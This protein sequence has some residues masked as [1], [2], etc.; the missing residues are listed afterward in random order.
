MNLLFRVPVVLILTCIA[1]LVIA[2]GSVRAETSIRFAFQGASGD[3]R[4]TIRNAS[5]LATAQADGTTAPQDL[6]AAAQ[7]DY[8]RILS[9]LYSEAYYGGVINILVDGREA[10]NLQVLS[11][12]SAINTIVVQVQPGRIYRFGTAEVA[13]VPRRAELPEGF[14]SGAPAFSDTISAAGSSAIEAWRAD[15]F[16][17]AA[18]AQQRITAEH[19]NQ[20][21]NARLAVA[22]GPRLRFG[23][24]AITGN[25]DVSAR[26]IRTIAGLQPGPVFDPEEVDRAAARLRRTGSFASVTIS[27][28]TAPPGSDGLP[29][30]IDVVEATPRRFGFGAEI[31]TIEG[32][33]LSGFWLHRN[34]LGGAE[35]FRIDGEISGLG[36]ETG[37]VDYST[38]IRYERPATPRA[39]VD[40]FAELQF[41]VLDEP[42][43]SSDTVEFTLGFTRYATDD[44]TVEAGIGYLF[45]QTTDAF[46]DETFRLLT[47]PLAAEYDKRDNTLNP[48]EGF[49]IDLSLTPFA[50][51]SG[52]PSGGQLELDTRGYYSPNERFTFATR[53]QLGSL[54]GPS[55]E[56]SPP[57]YRFFSGGGG[58]VR[59][60]DFQSLGVEV[61]GE[62]LGG[63]SFLGLSG[64]VRTNVT[65]AIQ[66]VGFADW[67][68][69]GAEAFPDFTGDGHA[70]VGLGL[71]YNTGIGPIRLD[72]ATP[73]GGDGNGIAILVGIGQAF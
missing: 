61:S 37:G 67:G 50:G 60:Q 18:I 36:G 56:D 10:A 58:T 43:F 62:T 12:P 44:L 73:V 41:E 48:T 27:E 4:D 32:L 3:L 30:A 51:L 47:L 7:A 22:P 54:F 39:D 33:G 8:A 65:E 17:T 70:G 23:D 55:L 16:A 28:G 25:E 63:R 29:L 52:S 49:Y 11:P 21:I 2:A 59:G 26:R 6:L 69:I 31:G 19:A 38:G 40:L 15:G 5:L 53:V 71:R 13:P 20:R 64:E 14:Q 35:R 45:S 66:V 57:F 42:D 72:L 9:A 34:L 24:V 68:Y 46:G 1:T